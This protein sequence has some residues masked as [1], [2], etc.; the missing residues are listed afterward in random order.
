MLI[1][2][3]ISI[4]YVALWLAIAMLFSIVFRSVA[5]SALA[6]LATWIFFSFFISLGAN[7]V[8]G[9]VSAGMSGTDTEAIIQQLKISQAI[10]LLSP[11]V[12]Y[13]DSTSIIID[14]MKNTVE[15]ITQMGVMEQ[16]SMARFS[17]PLSLDQ[18]VL[19]IL[20]YIISLVAI[21]FIC[22]TVSYGIFTKQEIRSI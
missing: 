12:L 16:I 10:S 19:L 14:P 18:S 5:T 2:L 21:T 9:A 11:L 13:S 1:Y 3:L 4:I 8:A 22:F 15:T 20:P 17:G 6:A 7:A